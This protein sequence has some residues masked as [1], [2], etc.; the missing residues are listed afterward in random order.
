MQEPDA[1][2]RRGDGEIKG[3]RRSNRKPLAW[4]AFRRAGRSGRVPRLSFCI[5]QSRIFS[6]L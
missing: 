4:L 2:A 5:M 1:Y 6:A 3:A